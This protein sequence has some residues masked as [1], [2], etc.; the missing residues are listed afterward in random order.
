MCFEWDKR[1]FRELEEKKSKEQVDALL[2]KAEEA[3][4]LKV[5]DAETAPPASLNENVLT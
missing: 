3:V 4:S 2:K 5:A 1:Y